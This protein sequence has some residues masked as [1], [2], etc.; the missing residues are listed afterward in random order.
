MSL[1]SALKS[2]FSRPGGL[3]PAKSGEPQPCSCGG[4]QTVKVPCPTCD[5]TGSVFGETCYLCQGQKTID[6]D[7]SCKT[8]K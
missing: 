4:S 3:T 1:L 6:G 2:L 8:A 5:G 7:C